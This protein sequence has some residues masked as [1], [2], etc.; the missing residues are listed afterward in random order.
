MS[1]LFAAAIAATASAQTFTAPIHGKKTTQ[2]KEKAPP[3]VYKENTSGVI[4]RAVA[5]GNPLQ[6]LNPKAPP[7]YGTAE[8]SVTYEPYTG[9]WKGIKLFTI[10]F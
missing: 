4:P 3:P 9:K 2:K 8:E 1:I 5:G 10:N 6:M 7:Q